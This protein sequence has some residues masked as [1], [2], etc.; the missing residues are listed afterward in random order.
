MI[1][2]PGPCSGKG[3]GYGIQSWGPSV[4]SVGVKRRSL[5]VIE[6]PA[7]PMM[8]RMSKARR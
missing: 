5:I 8:D 6:M 2:F 3:S 1:A 4:C 7:R